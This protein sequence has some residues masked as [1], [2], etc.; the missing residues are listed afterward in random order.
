MKIVK[1]FWVAAGGEEVYQHSVTLSGEVYTARVTLTRDELRGINYRIS[2]AEIEQR[3]RSMLLG[4]ISSV[5]YK[6]NK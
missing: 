1:D 5:L 3:L 2:L 4:K 6:D